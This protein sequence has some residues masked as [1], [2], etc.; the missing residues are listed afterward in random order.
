[1]KHHFFAGLI[2]VVASLV[3]A[4]SRPAATVKEK[5]FGGAVVRE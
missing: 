2:L 4:E 1:M 3:L 5:D